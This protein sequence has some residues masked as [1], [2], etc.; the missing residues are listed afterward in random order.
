MAKNYA[1]EYRKTKVV[2]DLWFRRMYVIAF[3][4]YAWY[5]PWRQIFVRHSFD[6]EDWT[7]WGFATFGMYYFVLD[8][9]GILLKS[10]AKEDI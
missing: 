1:N 6:W 8:S 3:N 2:V 4:I 10:K 9:K 7:L 5:W